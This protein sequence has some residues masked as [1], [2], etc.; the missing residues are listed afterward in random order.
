MCPSHLSLLARRCAMRS[1]VGSLVSAWMDLPVITDRHLAFQFRRVALFLVLNFHASYPWHSVEV[2]KLLYSCS[3]RSRGRISSS[4]T[5][6]SSLNLL[7]AIAALTNIMCLVSPSAWKRAPR[8]L[9][10][11]THWMKHFSTLTLGRFCSSRTDD[12]HKY[13]QACPRCT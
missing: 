8:Y 3:L 5:E 4:Q 13:G 7:L 9:K 10:L 11:N 2:T 1:K 6:S 12:G